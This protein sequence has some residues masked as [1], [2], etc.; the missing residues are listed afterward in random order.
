MTKEHA[1]ERTSG[2]D[3]GNRSVVAS[4]FVTLDGYM[5]G[6]DEDISWVAEGFDPEMQEDIAVAMSREVGVFVFGRVTF[7]IFAEYWPSAIPL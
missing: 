5:V 1:G 2:T 6:P 7:E 3:S 4:T